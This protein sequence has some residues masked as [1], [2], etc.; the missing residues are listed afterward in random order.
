MKITE[1]FTRLW[2]LVMAAER[3]GVI[4]CFALALGECLGQGSMTL[5]FDGQPRGTLSQVG[6]YSEGRIGFS[7]IPFGV[8][9]LWGGGIT[10]YPENGTGYLW[11]PSNGPGS[12]VELS[13]VDGVSLFNMVS[14]D[15]AES[16]GLGS[17]VLTVVGYQPQIMGP[18][19]VITNVFTTD[20]INDGTG[21]LQDFETFYLDPRFV[22]L[23]RV[24]IYARFSLDN[25]VISGVPEPSAAGLMLLGIC[26]AYWRFSIKNTRP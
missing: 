12:G 11:V 15:A 10:G 9:Y 5:R 16:A 6:W 25:L 3:A 26:C 22:N 19:T 7:A 23:L 2:P 17:T 20:G 4:L 1:S 24:D 8:L 21:P 13:S 18:T 14:F